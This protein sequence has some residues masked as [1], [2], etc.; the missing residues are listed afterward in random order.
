MRVKLRTDQCVY[1]G[2]LSEVKKDPPERVRENSDLT[3]VEIP[4][5][6]NS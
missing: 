3:G 1:V 2:K 6:S 5:V 4:A